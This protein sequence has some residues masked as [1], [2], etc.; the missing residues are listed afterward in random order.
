MEQRNT[1]FVFWID[2]HPGAEHWVL[3]GEYLAVSGHAAIQQYIAYENEEVSPLA[4]CDLVA[5]AKWAAHRS[6]YEP[7]P[8]H[9]EIVE[10]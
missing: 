3:Q 8:E 9:H 1:Y 6:H 7:A 10:G 2:R 4:T 5:V